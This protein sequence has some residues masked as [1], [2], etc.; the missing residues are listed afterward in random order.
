MRTEVCFRDSIPCGSLSP[1]VRP[2]A[3]LRLYLA[4]GYGALWSN[5][6]YLAVLSLAV[7]AAGRSSERL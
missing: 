6:L 3:A 7:W 4:A 2:Q 1:G 5:G